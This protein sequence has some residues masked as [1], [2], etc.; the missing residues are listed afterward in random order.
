MAKTKKSS[1]S[2]KVKVKT[3]AN[4]GGKTM[5]V[6]PNPNYKPVRPKPVAKEKPAKKHKRRIPLLAKA[7]VL[8]SIFGGAAFANGVYLSPRDELRQA[9]IIVAISGG[10][11]RGRT[12]LAA[13]VYKQGWAQRLI[14]SG[15]TEQEGVI[16][17]AEAMRNIA[18]ESG[19]PEQL[20][21]LSVN[22]DNTS[23]NAN[24]VV[25]LLEGQDVS[26]IILITSEYH[27]RRASIDFKY[28]LENAGLGSV[29][30]IN[31]P[32]NET[33][34]S[35]GGWWTRPGGWNLT[36]SEDIKIAYNFISRKIDENN[37]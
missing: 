36:V 27:Q 29:E 25:D 31:Y 34:W 13:D 10:D 19:V 21:D 14:F 11:T 5:D 23:Q 30:I 33:G 2:T 37:D 3:N 17:N 22:A 12:L 9:D 24:E 15:D 28:E 18:V 8:L 7:I 32:Y 1:T 26:R 35:R 4:S 20:I 16:S 6:K